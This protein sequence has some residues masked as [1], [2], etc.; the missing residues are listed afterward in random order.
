MTVIPLLLVITVLTAF[1]NA[2]EQLLM[3]FEI[4]AGS[5]MAKVC[6]HCLTIHFEKVG[7][8]SKLGGNGN[9]ENAK[10]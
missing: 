4:L 9:G 8:Y 7:M 2:I 5:I 6:L 10:P 1:Q 3:I